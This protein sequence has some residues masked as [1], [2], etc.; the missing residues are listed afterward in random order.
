ISAVWTTLVLDRDTSSSRTASA[1]VW[2][3]STEQCRRPRPGRWKSIVAVLVHTWYLPPSWP[4]RRAPERT[5]VAAK[6][7]PPNAVPLVLAVHGA[8][9][10]LSSPLV[11]SGA[12][13]RTRIPEPIRGGEREAS[14]V[15]RSE[16]RRV[17]NE[18]SDGGGG[19]DVD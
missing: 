10:M 16:E 5:S 19:R 15:K 1:T 12:I 7:E 2:G 3:T 8:T 11:Q 6:S 17:G 4:D 13:S 18:G 9:R 14:T